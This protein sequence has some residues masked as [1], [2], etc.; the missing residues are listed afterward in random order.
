MTSLCLVTTAWCCDRAAC[1]NKSRRLGV[2][3][4]AEATVGLT[5]ETLAGT[6]TIEARANAAKRYETQT[7][8]N[9]TM[10]FGS[11]ASGFESFR[12]RP[13]QSAFTPGQA[14]ASE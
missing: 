5:A 11:A 13:W 7:G 8:E 1:K 10:C 6:V 9:A 4:T 12:P 14:A 2:P 3:N